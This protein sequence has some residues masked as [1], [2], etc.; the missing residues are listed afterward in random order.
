MKEAF[1]YD[2]RTGF[3]F[4]SIF[5][6]LDSKGHAQWVNITPGEKAVTLKEI[7][8]DADTK[9]YRVL[10]PVG[11]TADSIVMAKVLFREL[12]RSVGDMRAGMEASIN[13][14]KKMGIVCDGKPLELVVYVTEDGEDDYSV[15][16]DLADS[17]DVEY[18]Y[19]DD[20]KSIRA[21]SECVETFVG[22]LEDVVKIPIQKKILMYDEKL[23]NKIE[24][25]FLG[26]NKYTNIYCEK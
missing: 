16:L 25:S 23:K 15:S 10:C 8:F 12:D 19:L 20:F 18:R 17:V 24:E 13:S 7:L 22:I 14:M 5:A 21:I 6:G 1:L 3:V 9:H 2:E 26:K 11:E 4:R